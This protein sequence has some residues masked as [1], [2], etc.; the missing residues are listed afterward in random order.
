LHD[1]NGIRAAGAI[2][3]QGNAEVD[4]L[5]LVTGIWR[6]FLQRGG[7]MLANTEIVDVDETRN[8]VRLNTREGEHLQAKWV[9]FCTGYEQLRF[10]KPKGY[11]II[12]TWVLATKQQPEA[13]WREKSLIWQAADPYLYLRTTHDGRVIVGGEDEEFS[14]EATRDKATPGK[15]A[16]IAKKAAK[17]FPRLDFEAA[18]SWAGCFGESATSLPAVGLIKGFARSYSVLGFGG[19]G[20]TFSMM[21]AQLISRHIQGLKDPDAELFRL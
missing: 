9:V 20:I 3:T 14:D 2:R 21:A 5:K 19:N 10:V 8:H 15:I 17:I 12:S 4:P 18:Y 7:K 6:A 16:R 1:L 13:L 11:K